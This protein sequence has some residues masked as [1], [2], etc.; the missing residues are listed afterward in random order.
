MA[1]VVSTLTMRSF[2]VMNNKSLK[3]I[4]GAALGVVCG[5]ILRSAFSKSAPASNSADPPAPAVQT[6]AQAIQPVA[7]GTDAPPPPPGVV[8][9]DSGGDGKTVL[10][11]DGKTVLPEEGKTVLP[12]EGKETLPPV[13]EL[14]N[15][16]PQMVDQNP[17]GPPTE[18]LR[19]NPLLTPPSP[20]NVSGP[21]VSPET[22]P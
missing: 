10:P 1:S 5:L 17:V 21:V 18:Y 15:S 11:G 12:T 20:V 14:F 16:Q 6:D 13:A 22:R 8:A 19:N 2:Y 9:S 7:S 3:L 4:A